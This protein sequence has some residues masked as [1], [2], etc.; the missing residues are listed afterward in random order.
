V[1]NA[2]D[3]FGH[4][5]IIIIMI[6]RICCKLERERGSREKKENGDNVKYIYGKRRKR[7][8]NYNYDVH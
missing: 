7:N 1:K 2:K 8:R 4:S 5:S 6:K 3:T